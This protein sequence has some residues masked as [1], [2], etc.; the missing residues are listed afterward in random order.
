VSYPLRTPLQLRQMETCSKALLAFFNTLTPIMKPGT[1]GLHLES[2]LQDFCRLQGIRS[3]LKDY[4][5]FPALLCVN[6]NHCPA[7][8][9]PDARPFQAGDVITVDCAIA[10]GEWCADMAWTWFIDDGCA[11]RKHLVETAWKASM[12]AALASAQ[13][14]QAM[15]LAVRSVVGSSSCV[16]LPQFA[17]HAIGRQIHE[18][19]R[20]SYIGEP[21]TESTGVPETG[22]VFTV[23]PVLAL[24]IDGTVPKAV[25]VQTAAGW[26]LP[27]GWFCAQFEF[28]VSLEQDGPRLLGFGK[29]P[30]AALLTNRRL[31]GMPA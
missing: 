10:K 23:E 30:Q 11:L 15:G 8:G 28:M 12:A 18:A 19:P 1:T 14:I 25:P 20:L 31:P 7:H 2:L 17:G 6:V 13:G 26:M 4:R 5:G 24:R 16:L 21:G 29:H 3:M 27:E 9:V 22:M